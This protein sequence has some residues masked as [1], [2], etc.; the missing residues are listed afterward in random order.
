[1]FH[2][3]RLQYDELKTS[4]LSHTENIRGS[5]YFFQLANK[6][7]ALFSP[8]D[9]TLTD[10]FGLCPIKAVQIAK[11]LGEQLE[12]NINGLKAEFHRLNDEI[13]EKFAQNPQNEMT[14]EEISIRTYS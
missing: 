3:D 5:A 10:K 6:V 14:L 1:M 13:D 12:E 2:P 8:Y 9:Q 11:A 7:N 4:L